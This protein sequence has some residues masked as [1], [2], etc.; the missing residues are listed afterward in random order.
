MV[1]SRIKCWEAVEGVAI[2]DHQR[3]ISEQVHVERCYDGS[4]H[5]SLSV[6]AIQEAV[7][8]LGDRGLKVRTGL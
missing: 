7:P 8:L 4:C 3:L 6:S 5:M 1:R 2:R